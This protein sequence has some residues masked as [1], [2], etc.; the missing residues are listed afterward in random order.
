[1]TGS[2]DARHVDASS[3]PPTGELV[4]AVAANDLAA[5]DRLLERHA[6]LR[7]MLNHPLPELAFGATIL[8]SAVYASSRAMADLLLR[9]GA[10]VN[11]KSHWWAGGF[12]AL[13]VCTQEFAPFL[14]ERGATLTA[15]AA[16]RL[17]WLDALRAIVALDPGAVHQRGGDGQTPL[18]VAATVE[19]ARLLID[20]GAEVDALDVDHESTPLQYAIRDR[21]DVARLLV[22]R[23]ARLDILAASALG[24]RDRVRE[25]LDAE[26]EAIRT[27]VSAEYFPMRDPRAGGTIYIWTL[28]AHRTAHGV[29]R[30][31]GHDDVEELLRGRTPPALAL[32]LACEL[33]DAETVARLL[34]DDPELSS[35]L[36]ESERRRLVGAAE[37]NM[38][39]A[40]ARMLDAGWPVGVRDGRGA[41]ALHFAAWHGNVPMMREILKRGPSIQVEDDAFRATPLEWALH[42][43]Q[44][45]W[46]RGAGDYATTIEVLLAA[47]A[48]PPG[49][50]SVQGSRAALDALA[51]FRPADIDE[52]VR[53]L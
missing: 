27:T 1:M 32:A 35:R 34:S 16:S 43:S 19:T 52:G 8:S 14:I 40:V 31:F 12:A 3:A 10:D 9:H 7:G 36:E 45:A 18:H 39:D 51:R 48:T 11:G 49:A 17:G 22:D 6:E 15:Y 44:N 20:H 42:G 2:H 41:T 4:R 26:P 38:T 50:E 5:A 21:Q 46:S 37:R 13:D 25:I 24:E 53:G 30:E 29:A 47:G 28:G 33:G 23:G